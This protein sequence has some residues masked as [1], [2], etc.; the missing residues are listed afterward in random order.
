MFLFTKKIN[1]FLFRTL[2][3]GSGRTTEYNFEI[4][5]LVSYRRSKVQGTN[6]KGTDQT[7]RMRRLVCSFVG[8]VQQKSAFPAS[9]ATLIHVTH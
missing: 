2:I 3:W 6:N 5:C 1:I 8:R 7:A 4:V 9:R